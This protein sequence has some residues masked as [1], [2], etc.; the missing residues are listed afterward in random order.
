[1]NV[2]NEWIDRNRGKKWFKSS[3]NPLQNR[4][5]L[6]FKVFKWWRSFNIIDR[7]L[8][9]VWHHHPLGSIHFLPLCVR[10][11]DSIH[12]SQSQFC[13]SLIS[14][15]YQLQSS[16]SLHIAA[17]NFKLGRSRTLFFPFSNRQSSI[18]EHQR[19]L[20]TLAKLLKI[21]EHIVK[22]CFDTWI[23]PSSTTTPTSNT[24][25][26]FLSS[27]IFLRNQTLHSKP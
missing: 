6:S 14:F 4:E 1:M 13:N 8:E 20:F 15:T 9:R 12:Q 10:F 3:R 24:F 7:W 5:V 25:F 17:F 2:T 22:S 21:N 19:L 27:H 26:T 16:P 11:H 18:L 23:F